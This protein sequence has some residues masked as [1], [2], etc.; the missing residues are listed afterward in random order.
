MRVTVSVN[1]KGNL[2]GLLDRI[3]EGIEVGMAIGGEQMEQTVEAL[4]NERARYPTGELEGTITYD[5]LSFGVQSEARVVMGTDHAYVYEYGAARHFVPKEM[6]DERIRYANLYNFEPV[7]KHDINPP[8]HL[9]TSGK[10][11]TYYYVPKHGYWYDELFNDDDLIGYWVSTA[12]HRPMTDG[13]TATKN[14]LVQEVA[15]QIAAAV[16][17]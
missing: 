3:I 6:L 7:Y 10:P 13:F 8:E 9:Y 14:T 2:D 16:E 12:P 4:A 1:R 11:N 17:R 15:N 5:P